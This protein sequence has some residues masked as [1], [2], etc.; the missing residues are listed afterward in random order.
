M[1]VTGLVVALGLLVD[2]SIVMTDEIR[3]RLL[4]GRAASD[5]SHERV[6]SVAHADPAHCPPPSPPCSLFCRWSCFPAPGGDFLGSIAVAVDGDARVLISCWRSPSRLYWLPDGCLLGHRAGAP[7][8]ASRR[9]H[10]STRRGTSRRS[11]N[12][13]IRNPLGAFALALGAPHDR[14]SLRLSTLTLQFF[15]GTDRD[16]MYLDVKLPEGASIDDSL[17]LGHAGRPKAARRAAHSAVSTGRSARPRP[18]SITTSAAIRERAC[19]VGPGHWCLTTDENQTDALIRFAC[20]G[21]S[22]GNSPRRRSWC[23]ASTRAPPSTR[24]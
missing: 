23:A 17:A 5:R 21:K 10:P 4:T 12:W 16:Q 2:G 11:L 18:S 3:K 14:R 9:R 19:R 15:P 1:S 13:S 24:R 22:T 6:R 20:S 8:V 7:L